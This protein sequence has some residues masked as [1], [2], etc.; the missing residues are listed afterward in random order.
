VPLTFAGDAWQDYTALAGTALPVRINTGKQSFDEDLLFTHRGLSGPAILQISSYWQA[1]TP[2]TID[3][4]PGKDLAKLWVNLKSGCKDS[5]ATVLKNHFSQRQIDL[6]LTQHQFDK[7]LKLADCSNTTLQ[8]LAATLQ[9]WQLTPNGSE[10][11]AKAEVTVGGVSTQELE[12]SSCESKKVPG[13]FF[14]GEVVDVTGW[15]G[16]YNFQW[17]WSSG[18]VAGMAV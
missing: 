2:I 15:L 3:L 8:N 14:I 18:Y 5:L 1:N 9:A 4:A 6:I 16:G 10:G 17:A 13:L 12:Q 7:H 11:Y